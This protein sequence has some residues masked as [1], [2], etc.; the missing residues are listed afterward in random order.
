[1]FNRWTDY[2]HRQRND[3]PEQDET[4]GSHT[5][6][7]PTWNSYRNSMHHSDTQQVRAPY[8]PKTYVQQL[9]E[10]NA[11]F[12]HTAGKSSTQT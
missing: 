4:Q 5:N 3:D 2:V 12:R 10:L 9:Q 8:K 11:P 7:K 6:L 1:M